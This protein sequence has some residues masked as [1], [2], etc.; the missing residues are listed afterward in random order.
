MS[1]HPVP[2]LPNYALTEKI[3]TGSYGVVYKAHAKAGTRDV[4]AV[5]CVWRSGLAKHE[6]ENIVN[7]ISLLKKLKH[8]HIVVLKDFACDQNYIYIVMDYCGGGDLSHYIRNNTKLSE[9]V[10]KLFLQQLG[11]ALKY[12]RQILT[13]FLRRFIFNWLERLNEFVIRKNQICIFGIELEVDPFSS[14]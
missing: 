2:S 12:L 14:S 11:S 6:V 5:K 3:G 8:D 10:V 7:E 9:P 4:V 13:L 1:S